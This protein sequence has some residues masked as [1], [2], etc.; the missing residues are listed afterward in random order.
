MPELPEVETV[1]RGLASH[2]TGA[3]CT[4]V[5]VID[6]RLLRRHGAPAAPHPSGAEFAHSLLGQRIGAVDRRGKFL[7]M[8]LTDGMLPTR[9]I[10]QPA[11][12]VALV[13]HLGMSGQLLLRDCDAATRGSLSPIPAVDWQRD[14]VIHAQAR[15]GRKADTI[16]G[17]FGDDRLSRVA[18]TLAE[19]HVRA[20]LQ[21][22]RA[23]GRAIELSFVDQRV[24]GRLALEPLADDGSGRQVPGSVAAIAPDPLESAFDE[25]A[26]IAR[27]QASRASIKSL[28]LDQRLV[29]GVGNIYADES[30]W[31]AR[32]YW[33][34]AGRGIA[35]RA[36]HRLLA[37]VREVFAESLSQGGTSFDSLYINVNGES[38]YFS[39]SLTVYGQ[40][41]RPCP[42]CGTLIRRERFRS[43]SSYYCPRCQRSR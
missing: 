1:R 21:L 26:V 40:A 39:R 7:W 3:V 5:D 19:P 36:L 12:A 38:G 9:R 29:S 16:S 6:E 33:A 14:G 10:L 34:R 41:G 22:M 31:R 18:L 30:L 11:Q 8:P 37:A 28:L 23:D 35:T 15:D 2:I 24:F 17:E 13:A 42:R 32:I 4:G 25:A 20:R 43:R 27:M